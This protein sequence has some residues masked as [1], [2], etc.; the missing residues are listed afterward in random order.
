MSYFKL[1]CILLDSLYCN[2][3]QIEVGD[4]SCDLKRQLVDRSC[5]WVVFDSLRRRFPC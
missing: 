4:E 5:I 2:A 3:F 1:F